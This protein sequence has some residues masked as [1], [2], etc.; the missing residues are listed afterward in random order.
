MTDFRSR[1]QHR[2]NPLHIYCRLRHMG[3]ADRAARAMTGCYE[4]T[5]YRLI[6]A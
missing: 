4:R 3:V 6:F 5:F 2:F 1:F